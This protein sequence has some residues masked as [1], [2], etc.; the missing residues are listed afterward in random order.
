MTHQLDL[1]RRDDGRWSWRL[2]NVSGRVL[3]VDGT[4]GYDDVATAA[5]T[6]RDVLSG[7]LEVVFEDELATTG[8]A[9]HGA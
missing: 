7:A 8:S 1:F 6:A 5:M 9:H 2:H 4:E 3:A